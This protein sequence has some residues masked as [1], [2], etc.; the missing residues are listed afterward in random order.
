[1]VTVE[2]QADKAEMKLIAKEEADP[3]YTG[4]KWGDENRIESEF[5]LLRRRK[6]LRNQ[7]REL[8]ISSVSGEGQEEHDR[9]ALLQNMKSEIERLRLLNERLNGKEL[10]G[11]NYYELEILRCEISIGWGNVMRERLRRR[12]ESISRGEMLKGVSGQ[13]EHGQ[14]SMDNATTQDHNV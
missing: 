5:V 6:N 2:R 3:D 10:D 13:T 1:M 7:A 11:L 4:L 14:S 8:R 12:E 9:E